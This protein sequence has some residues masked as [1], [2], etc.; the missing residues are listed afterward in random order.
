MLGHRLEDKQAE[1]PEM[2]AVPR[3][4]TCKVGQRLGTWI[5]GGGFPP[6]PELK[7]WHILKPTTNQTL[8]TTTPRGQRHRHVPSRVFPFRHEVT[9]EPPD[10][11]KTTAPAEQT[12]GSVSRSLPSVRG[13]PRSADLA[14]C[15][16]TGS[17]SSPE[18]VCFLLMSPHCQDHRRDLSPPN[19]TKAA[20]CFITP[21]RVQDTWR[22]RHLLPTSVL[23]LRDGVSLS[24][25]ETAA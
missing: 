11:N 17:V 10:S 16:D 14:P 2:T 13:L 1:E 18:L 3:K 24:H 23:P 25:L 6:F 4:A 8:E 22:R 5:R 19:H 21:D 7:I 9:Q 20:L 15:D 12:R